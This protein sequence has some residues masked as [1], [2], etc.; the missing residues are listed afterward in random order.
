MS[1]KPR[2]Q[3]LWLCVNARRPGVWMLPF[4]N[5][6]EQRLRPECNLARS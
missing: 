6:S 1:T 3:A 5:I 2:Q 4:R